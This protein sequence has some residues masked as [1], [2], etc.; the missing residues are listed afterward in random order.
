LLLFSSALEFIV[1]KINMINLIIDAAKDKIFFKI[2]TDN[3]SYTSEYT[4]SREN[5]DKFVVLLFKLLEKNKINIKK[6]NNIFINQGP[7]KFSGIR[8]SIAAAKGLSVTNQLNL[9]GFNSDQV[10]D[11]NYNEIIDLFNKGLLKKNLIKPQ[12]S[13]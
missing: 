7:G 11:Q 2:I 10:N 13:S 9:Y 1:K 3:K 6:I 8:A 5:F 4:N 12:Y